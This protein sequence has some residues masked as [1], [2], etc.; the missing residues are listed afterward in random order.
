MHGDDSKVPKRR[1]SANARPPPERSLRA[2]PFLWRTNAN[3]EIGRRIVIRREGER[4]REAEAHLESSSILFA[5]AAD[6]AYVDTLPQTQCASTSSFLGRSSLP[7]S[8]ASRLLA[9]GRFL[10]MWSGILR[11]CTLTTPG[12]RPR[13]CLEGAWLACQQHIVKHISVSE[14]RRQCQSDLR[15]Q[16]SNLTYHNPEASSQLVVVAHMAIDVSSGPSA[17]HS[18][19]AARMFQVLPLCACLDNAEPTQ[20]YGQLEAAISP[21]RSSK[22]RGSMVLAKPGVVMLRKWT[23]AV[24]RASFGGIGLRLRGPGEISTSE[25][26]LS[27]VAASARG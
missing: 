16:M 9:R 18:P 3:C 27:W 11:T 8:L 2:V 26:L 4:E 10:M 13:E 25:S 14:S 15:D 19:P 24:M 12:S 17:R 22:F 23:L 20:P 7:S 5:A 21:S 1:T 6:H